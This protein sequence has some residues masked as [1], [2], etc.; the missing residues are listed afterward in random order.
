MTL[1][2][3]NTCQCSNKNCTD[4]K[5]GCSTSCCSKQ[6]TTPAECPFM[7]AHPNWQ[8]CPFMRNMFMTMQQPTTVTDTDAQISPIPV[9]HSTCDSSK[10]A[11]I[12][13]T[14]C[15]SCHKTPGLNHM[16]TLA[17]DTEEAADQT[18]ETAL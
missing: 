17:M 10:C 16:V 13:M 5:C 2:N 12:P 7:K 15:T 6:P 3:E 18:E 4:C 9:D 11:N 8:K 1:A 14:Q